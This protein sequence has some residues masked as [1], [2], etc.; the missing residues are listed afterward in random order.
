MAA[1]VVLERGT[2]AHAR[3][4]APLLRAADVA[5]VWASN[6]RTGLEALEQSV[7]LSDVSVAMRINGEVASM[8]GVRA[9]YPLPALGWSP[10]GVVWFLTGRAWDTHPLPLVRAAKRL[11]PE[12]QEVSGCLELRNWLDSRYAGALRLATALGFQ[13]LDTAPLGPD[14]VPFHLMARRA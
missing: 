10:L 2:L 6:R 9:I 12:L 14:A 4:L 13:R 7:A 1:E 11:M 8:F 5:E 3:E